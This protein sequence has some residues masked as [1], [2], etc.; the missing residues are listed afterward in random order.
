MNVIDRIK[1]EPVVIA[2]AVLAL[3]T[4]LYEAYV[5]EGGLTLAIV[6]PV[7]IAFITRLFTVPAAEVIDLDVLAANDP[8][9]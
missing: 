7:V 8:A 2:G 3:L 6:V 9:A 5:A 4:A 1:R